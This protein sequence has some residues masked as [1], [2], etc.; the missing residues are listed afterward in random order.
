MGRITLPCLLDAGN[1]S[2]CQDGSVIGRFHRH[3]FLREC[4]QAESSFSP[5]LKVTSTLAH[6]PLAYTNIFQLIYY[7]NDVKEMKGTYILVT[8]M[9]A[10]PVLCYSQNIH[11][12]KINLPK[13]GA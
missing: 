7:I 3:A 2:V 9:V 12:S 5:T 10:K 4:T 8:L 11:V 1:E 6:P 13:E